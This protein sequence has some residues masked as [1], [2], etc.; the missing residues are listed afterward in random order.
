M[1]TLTISDS[2]YQQLE[3]TAHH[4]GFDSIEQ[5]LETLNPQVD[6]MEQRH[7]IVSQIDALRTKLY[8]VYGEMPDSIDLLHEDR[9]R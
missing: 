2:L 6:E 5:F 8:S 9:A 1:R 4:R 3:T 7:Q